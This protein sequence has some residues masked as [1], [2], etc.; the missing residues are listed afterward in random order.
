MR[1]RWFAVWLNPMKNPA[2]EMYRRLRVLDW[3]RLWE[4]E[5]PRFNAGTE[6]YRAV[7]V[8]LV[9]A[10]GV[11]FLE[12][13]PARQQEAV[14][15]WL[16]G[17]LG[18]PVER[19]RRYA[20]SALP[21][22]GSREDVE[23]ELSVVA[24][25]VSGER[26]R[27]HVGRALSKVGGR[28]AL[29]VAE[30][31]A[32]GAAQKIKAGA[33]RESGANVCLDRMV[34]GVAGLGMHLRCRRGLEDLVRAEFQENVELSRALR[35]VGIDS[36]VVAL[37]VLRDV[38]PADLFAL[39]CFGTLNFVLGHA[40]QDAESIAR[41]IAGASVRRILRELTSG[42]AR[43]RL[44]FMG[45]GHRRGAVATIAER[46][47]ALAPELLNDARSAPWAV[48]LHPVNGGISVELRPRLSP[49]PRFSYRLA[50]VPAASH[51]PLAAA[52]ARLAGRGDSVWD[53]FCGS[54]LELA[55]RA[56]AGGVRWIYGSDLSAEA[57]RIAEG[58]LDAAGVGAQRVLRCCDFRDFPHLAGIRAG[59]LDQI[60]TNP[61]LGRRVP[62]P[63]LDGLIGDLFAVAA[64]V[65]R[66][67]GV[68]VLA[69]PTGSAPASGLPLWRDFS[70]RVDFGGFTCRIERYV[71]GG[72]SSQIKG[73]RRG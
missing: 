39:R 69:N 45:E 1:G 35:I 65:L 23:R 68:L 44:E 34:R 2:T 6:S 41:V 66:P 22:I 36:G 51:P 8:A 15:D 28:V 38:R 55:E 53:P 5:V 12:S 21:K 4:V 7:H 62:V 11:V 40:G 25:G 30:D 49:D 59:S 29:G 63:D 73:T 32:G 18:D 19:V 10:V 46:V 42:I 47:H 48:D 14:V 61:P 31:L 71:K 17:L 50:D 37:E 54:G 27:R 60:L 56:M 16:R 3:E 13:G 72:G 64:Q 26:E 20:M 9:R 52:M 43:Y 70:R 24:K 57:I 33:A 58:N 67:R